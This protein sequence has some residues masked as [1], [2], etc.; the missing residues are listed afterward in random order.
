MNNGLGLNRDF[1]DLTDHKS[2][3]FFSADTGVSHGGQVC[4][5]HDLPLS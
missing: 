2:P 1:Y 3:P 4:A 5:H